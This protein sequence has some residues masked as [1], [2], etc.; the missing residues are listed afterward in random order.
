MTLREEFEEEL[1]IKYTG[2]KLLL[3][4]SSNKYI[5]WLE[6]RI[7]Q[8]QTYPLGD[9]SKCPAW[10]DDQD[11]L[12]AKSMFKRN[13]IDAVRYLRELAKPHTKDPL[14]TAAELVK[15]FC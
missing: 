5:V 8:G 14:R 11:F 7:K 12:K 10:L 3:E 9:V 13:K 6:E 15:G 4:T 2:V 1:K